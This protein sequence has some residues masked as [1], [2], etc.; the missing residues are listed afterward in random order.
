[1]AES[2]SLAERLRAVRKRRGLSQQ[3]LA[4]VA[5]LSRS[6]VEKIEQGER[7]DVRMETA[8]K[9]ATALRVPT[10]ALL[11]RDHPEAEDGPVTGTQEAWAPV[12][13]ALAGHG[14][15]PDEEATAAGVIAASRDL[16]PALSGHHYSAVLTVLPALLRDA[17]ALDDGRDARKA[18]ADL[19]TTTGYLL[20]QTRQF[21]VAEMTLNRAIDAAGDRID[22]AAAA[23]TLVW[24]YLRQGRLIEALQT[25]TRWADELEPRFSRATVHELMTWGRFLLDITN[26]AI[27]D[28]RPGEA[29]DAL[30]LA[31]AAAARMGREVQ[32]HPN[33]QMVFGPVTVA[34]IRAEARVLTGHPD[35]ALKIAG[36]LP[37][38]P[39]FPGLVSRLRHRL[40]VASAHA[41]MSRYPDAVAVLQDVRQRAPE[42]L[43]Q[44]HYARDI[45]A[46]VIDR[47]RTLTP[48]MREL[49]DFVGVPL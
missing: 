33:S 25:A 26:A 5:G 21:P 41:Q 38:A 39:P 29:E 28:N 9:L 46:R 15:Q 31:A 43:P 1:M 11:L 35:A 17:D 47:R 22:A 14:P 3:E 32:R 34:Y 40:D 7:E 48:E 42:W 24:L 16:A 36:S 13:R 37:G 27:R 12:R 2:T 49:A 10:S 19:L 18:R 45:M 20:T 44:Q 6:L 30:D 23:D 4:A 8:L